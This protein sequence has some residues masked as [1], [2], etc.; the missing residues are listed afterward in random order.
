[1]EARPLGQPRLYDPVGAGFVESQARP[2][3]N[4]TGLILFE[5]S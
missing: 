4:A 2:R 1:L 5:D 3:G